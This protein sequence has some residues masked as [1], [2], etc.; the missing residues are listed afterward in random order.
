MEFF[1]RIFEL[2]LWVVFIYWALRKL[3]GWLRR[4]ARPPR[5][6]HQPPAPMKTL[7]R[8]PLCG[9]YVAED[10]SFRLEEDGKTLHFCSE[11]CR[12]RYLARQNRAA[13]A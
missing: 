12:A 2:L 11:Q 7:E 8:D 13:R 10:I 1:A 9:T 6:P 5:V 4:P 3:S